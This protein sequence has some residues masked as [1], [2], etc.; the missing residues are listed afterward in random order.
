MGSD[1]RKPVLVVGFTIFGI[2]PDAI[3]AYA[4]S[5]FVIRVVWVMGMKVD[6]VRQIQI[7]IFVVLL[8]PKSPGRIGVLTRRHIHND[9]QIDVT[10][11]VTVTTSP[12]AVKVDLFDFRMAVSPFDDFSP[13]IV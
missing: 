1:Q 2:K 4:A 10:V 12:A 11:G 7:R 3:T 8:V 6:F 5:Y 9:R 13:V